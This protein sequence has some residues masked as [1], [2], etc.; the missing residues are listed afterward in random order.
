MKIKILK[1][2]ICDGKPCKAGTTVNASDK[3]GRFLINTGR[4]VLSEA[5]EKPS[6]KKKAPVNKQVST[7]ELETR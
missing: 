4:A 3:D 6:A 7:D 1:A 2:T 5:K